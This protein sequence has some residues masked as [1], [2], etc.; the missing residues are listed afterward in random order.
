MKGNLVGGG[1][2]VILWDASPPFITKVVFDTS[3]F[4]GTPLHKDKSYF[5]G[6]REK[7]VKVN[8]QITML[9]LLCLQTKI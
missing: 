5:G 2:V 9:S 8:H 1:G 6:G 4:R 7:E 3:T